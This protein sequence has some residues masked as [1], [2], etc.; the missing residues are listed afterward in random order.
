MRRTIYS[1][2]LAALLAGCAAQNTGTIA[3]KDMGSFHVGGR[4]FVVS[5]KPVKK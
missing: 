2:L 3:L 4:E 1:A 5:G